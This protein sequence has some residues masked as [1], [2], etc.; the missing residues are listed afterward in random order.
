MGLQFNKSEASW[1]YGGFKSFRERLAED[2]KYTSALDPFLEHSDCDGSIPS[3]D[4]RSIASAL[5]KVIQDWDEDYDRTNGMLLVETMMDCY[6]NGED[7][8]FS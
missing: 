2:E 7:L 6:D 4:C 8:I 5:R 1:S 3:K